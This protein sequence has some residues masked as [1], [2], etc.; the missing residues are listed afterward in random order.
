[1]KSYTSVQEWLKSNPSQ[2]IID[3]VLNTV[4]RGAV[5]ESRKELREKIQELKRIESALKSMEKVELPIGPEINKRV[6]ELKKSISVLQKTLPV[7][8]YARK[9]PEEK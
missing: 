8:P 5:A 2:E 3:R 7:S 1:M 6:T 4:N 9:K